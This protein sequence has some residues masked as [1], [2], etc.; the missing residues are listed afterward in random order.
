M[1]SRLLKRATTLSTHVASLKTRHRKIDSEI[2][3]E[4]THAAPDQTKLRWLKT[5]R[6][7]LRDQMKHYE[8]ILKDLKPLAGHALARKGGVV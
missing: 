3:Q 4:H 1:S 2:T 8:A 6:L 5:R 7:M